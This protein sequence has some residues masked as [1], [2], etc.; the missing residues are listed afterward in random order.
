MA[1]VLG[2]APIIG[3]KINM[4]FRSCCGF[5]GNLINSRMTIDVGLPTSGTPKLE[6]HGGMML[7]RNLRIGCSFH[8]EQ[9]I[10]AILPG[11]IFLTGREDFGLVNRLPLETYIRCVVGSEMSPDAPAEL[12]KAHAVISRGWAVGKILGLHPEGD[13]EGTSQSLTYGWADTAS[14]NHD[15]CGFHVCS[16]DH[17]QRYQGIQPLSGERKAAIAETEG[18]I[19]IAPDGNP[20]DTRFSKCCGGRTEIFSTCWQ[21]IDM[22]CL[23]SFEDPWCDLSALRPGQRDEIMKGVLKG[24]DAEIPAWG[25]EESVS[26]DLI[27]KNLQERFGKDIGGVTGIS[28]LER[29]PSGRIKLLLV[30]GTEGEVEIGKELW[31][32]RLL[33]PSHLYSSCFDIEDQGE[34]FL[35]RGKGWGHGVGLCQIGAARMALEGYG[36]REILSFYYPGSEI[37]RL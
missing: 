18:L 30:K 17:C 2:P 11:E 22:P 37:A 1:P 29:G 36:W 7:L 34:G 33:S 31:I 35:L 27:R 8:W 23:D 9:T 24:Y 12:L 19:L 32:R 3:S 15:E 5:L 28:P 21:D 16:D 25:W 10:E 13:E 14:H 6:R 4:I 26:K 20:V